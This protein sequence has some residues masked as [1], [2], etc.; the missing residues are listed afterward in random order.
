[1]L[2]IIIFIFN[3]G[4]ILTFTVEKDLLLSIKINTIIFLANY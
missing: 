2:E 3:I 1:M 4:I